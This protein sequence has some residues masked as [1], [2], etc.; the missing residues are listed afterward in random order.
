M[1]EPQ[2]RS[3]ATHGAEEHPGT[4]L[5]IH[6]PQFKWI[7]LALVA[8]MVLLAALA[9]RIGLLH[10]APWA[11]GLVMGVVFFVL[12]GQGRPAGQ[13]LDWADQV[14]TRGNARPTV[15]GAPPPRGAG[16]FPD[17]Y[18]AEG[19][20]IFGNPAAGALSAGWLVELPDLQAASFTEQNRVQDALV[21]I[22]H[23]LPAEW[24]ASVQWWE[25]PEPLDQLLDYQA[26]TEQAAEPATRFLRNANFLDLHQRLQRGELRRKRLA[27][28]VGCKPSA[29][30]PP[31]RRV[32]AEQHHAHRL[33]QLAAAFQ[34]WDQTLNHSLALAG[35]R[36]RRLTDADLIRRW[37]ATLNPSLATRAGVDPVTHFDPERTLLDHCWHSELR[38]QRG[39]GFLLDGSYHAVLS[40]KRLPRETHPTIGYRLTRLPFGGCT[41][42][43]HLSRIPRDVAVARAQRDLDRLN[44]QLARRPDERLEVNRAQLQEKIRRLANGDILPLEIEI[45]LIVVA[46]TPEELRERVAI[47]K[48]S[49][50]D[51]N[52]AQYYEATLPATAR[53]LFARTLPGWLAG[54]HRC[55]PLYGESRYV[56]DLILMAGSWSGHPGPVEALFPGADGNLVNV[57]TFLGEGADAT[58][59]NLIILGSVGSGKSVALNKLLRETESA[60]AYTVIL[61]EGLSHAAY[62]RGLGAEPIVFRLDGNLTLN[63]FDTRR[64]PLGSFQRSTL[65]ATL[66]LMAGV[67]AEEDQA[68]R[69]S[70]LLARHLNQLYEDH[71]QDRL[72][73]WTAPQREALVREAFLLHRWSAERSLS[74]LEAFLEFREQ[75]RDRP[76]EVQEQ[77]ERCTAAELRQFESQYADEVLTL[78]YAG[79]GPEEQP[80]LSAF[81]EHLELA[82]EDEDACRWLALRLAAWC[83]GGNYGSLLDGASN[84]PPATRVAHYEQ[85]S[86]P[87]SARDLKT[88]LSVLILNRER[89]HILSLPRA[90]RKRIVIEEVSRFLDLPRAE[91]FLRELFEQFRKFNCQVSIVAQSYSRLADTHIRVAL[92]G[93]TRGWM[94]FNTGSREDVERLGRDL[95]LSRL[96]QETILRLPRPDQQTRSKFSEFLYFHTDARHPICGSVRY[97][98]LPDPDL[99]TLGQTPPR[100]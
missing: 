56:A 6:S 16:V 75:Q 83:R 65:T 7:A 77:L 39:E 11:L 28:F 29:V 97:F 86:L 35:G 87:D 91:V 73:T 19:I 51:L 89:Q 41:I 5:G 55:F 24:R 21:A 18:L 82:G 99:T 57:V 47:V 48:S 54:S 2:P 90:L 81:R 20:L 68:A 27:L 76:G 88:V 36:A 58:P 31:W 92:V 52:G 63:P 62:T 44:Q 64:L 12:L 17:A 33:A 49:I 71:A 3:T 79:L 46:P 69:Q 40:L 67:P 23:Q 94:I 98:R 10:A 32:R 60:Y 96:A 43:Y 1:T 85:G 53:N 84:V 26:Q 13:I 100:P 95:D 70:A 4:V 15:D 61:E 37:T 14:F 22:L 59:Q 45:L 42:T 38:A 30:R 80:T 8:A 34:E 72:G 9:P 66:A 93:N 78:V 74:Q 50:Q 25:D